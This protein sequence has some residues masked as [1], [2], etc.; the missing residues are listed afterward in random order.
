[1]YGD[2]FR[3][4]AF[5]LKSH[6][7]TVCHTRAVGQHKTG[8]ASN[9]PACWNS[10]LSWSKYEF[11]G[12]YSPHYHYICFPRISLRTFPVFF[13]DL[14]QVRP[15]RLIVHTNPSLH[16]HSEN[17]PEKFRV[18]FSRL[19]EQVHPKR[20][21]VHNNPLI[22]CS[23]RDFSGE[24]SRYFIDLGTRFDPNGWLSTLTPLIT[25]SFRELFR[26]FF[27]LLWDQIL[28]NG[29]YSSHF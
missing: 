11:N 7:R 5:L 25:S 24:I 16:L 29:G 28:T 8:G 6:T 27:F 10:V 23:F 26:S 15:K 1:M 3:T 4:T 14:D 9:S 18:F 19:G 13:Y 20:L 12:W 2:E 21:I 22:T 17:F